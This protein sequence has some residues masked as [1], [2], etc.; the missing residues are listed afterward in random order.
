MNNFLEKVTSSSKSS[1]LPMIKLESKATLN[2]TNEFNYLVKYLCMKIN[3]VEWSGILFFKAE[4]EINSEEGVTITPVDIYP[5]DMGSSGYT[6]YEIDEDLFDYYDAHPDRMGMKYGHIHSHNSMDAYFSG[7]DMAEIRDNAVNHAYY[8]SVVVNNAGKIVGKI[9]IPGKRKTTGDAVYSFSGI[10]GSL[11]NLPRK[12]NKEEDVVYVID[13]DVEIQEGFGDKL[14]YERVEKIM[15]P[16]VPDKTYGQ[17]VIPG[18]R[19]SEIV[20]PREEEPED[21]PIPQMFKECL[22]GATNEDLPDVFDNILGENE[23]PT[24]YDDIEF[25][26]EQVLDIDTL[27]E[28]IRGNQRN[29]TKYPDVKTINFVYRRFKGIINYYMNGKYGRLAKLINEVID[30]QMK[31]VPEYV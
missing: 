24:P 29:I 7:T 22:G 10:L 20:L 4:G 15:Q 27:I 18:F 5:M 1:N 8:V 2:I 11:I 3:R 14:F 26:I 12:T 19:R 16:K 17:Q 25:F 31:E 6:E 28:V 13:M 30:D 9:G 23:D 21:L